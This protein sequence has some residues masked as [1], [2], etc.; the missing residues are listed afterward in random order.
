M[1]L[2]GIDLGK[3]FDVV[4]VAVYLVSDTGLLFNGDGNLMAGICYSLQHLL[5][6][7]QLLAGLSGPFATGDGTYATRLHGPGC[8]VGCCL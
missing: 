1:A 6:A 7:M 3:L 4:D 5:H 8:I 2:I